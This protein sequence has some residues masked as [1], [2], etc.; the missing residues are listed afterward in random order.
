[1]ALHGPTPPWGRSCAARRTARP[2]NTLG[3]AHRKKA[4]TEEDEPEE[5]PGRKKNQAFRE[6][7]LKKNQEEKTLSHR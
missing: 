2:K 7:S 1:L 4:G 6:M 3:K 5:K